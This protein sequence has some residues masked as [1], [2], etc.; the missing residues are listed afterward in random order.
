METN[1]LAFKRGSR[2][3]AVVCFITPTP[4]SACFKADTICA[5]VNLTD[6]V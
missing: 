3:R 4:V 5:S 2:V 6:L 1:Q